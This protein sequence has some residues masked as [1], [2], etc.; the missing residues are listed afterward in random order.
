MDVTI[1]FAEQDRPSFC[2]STP[3]FLGEVPDR[4]LCCDPREQ[5][6]SRGPETAQ[7]L[8]LEAE[9]HRSRI[10]NDRPICPEGALP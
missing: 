6:R 7:S 1:L 5:G 3:R 8:L 2:R 10:R 4:G 9:G